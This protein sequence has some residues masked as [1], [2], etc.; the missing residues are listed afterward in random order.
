MKFEYDSKKP[1]IVR[2]VPTTRLERIALA[3]LESDLDARIG[4]TN[5][6]LVVASIGIRG[7]EKTYRGRSKVKEADFL[8]FAVKE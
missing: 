7:V 8:D 1:Q 2:L 4:R 3:K 6:S 5:Y